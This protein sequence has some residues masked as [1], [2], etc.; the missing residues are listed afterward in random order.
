[1]T[2]IKQA[3][4]SWDEYGQP[5][6]IEFDD[7]YF[8]KD[9]GLEESRYVFLQHN[10]LSQRMKQLKNNDIFVIGETGFGSG[11]NFLCAWQLFLNVSP[12]EGRL[13]FISVEKS[14]LTRQDLKK[15]LLLWRELKEFSE[16]LITQYE[17]V[18]DGFQHFVF[19]SGR[20]VLTL[21]VGDVIDQLPKL[22]T[23]IDAWFLDGFSPAKNPQMWNEGLFKQLA[24]LS[25]QE[26]SFATFTSAGFVK[27]GLQEAGFN[28]LKDKGF[29]RKR[30][31]LYGSFQKME[32]P[33][34]FKKTRP[35]VAPWFDR[36]ANKPFKER[37]AVVIGAGIAGASTAA[38]LAS[39]GWH[40]VVLERNADIAMEGSGN[41]QGILYLKLSAHQTLQSR[42][43]VE[44]FGYTRRLLAHL[45]SAGKLVENQD[46][47]NCGV[48][49][50]A[51]NEKEQ[52]R[53][54]QL[55]DAFSSSLLSF[56]TREQASKIAGVEVAYEGLLF[57]EAGWV[58]PRNLC[59]ALLKHPNIEVRCY[60]SVLTINQ[61]KVSWQAMQN[62]KILAEADIM[63]LA[64]ATEAKNFMMTN[65]L[66]VKAIRGQ[67]TELP[68]NNMTK[69]NTVICGDG[70]VSPAINE[71]Y[72]IGATFNFHAIDLKPN[73]QEH[74]EN[75]QMLKSVSPSLA[76]YLEVDR[77]ALD[78]LKGKV[79]YR[80]TATDYL[81]I[82]GPVADRKLFLNDYSALIKDS[83]KIPNIPCRWHEGLFLNVAHGSRGL[84]TAPLC[85]ELLANW[86]EN[87]PFIVEQDLLEA[88]HANRFYVRELRYFRP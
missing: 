76:N 31:M 53:Q 44:G 6:S 64:N 50:L 60:Q 49:Q 28:V 12:D 29:A 68:A 73:K 84:I 71:T 47:Q 81:P 35:A 14:P 88:C 72:C 82:V 15:S 4:L 83:K 42:L 80:C 85:G 52:Y 70:Y 66:P 79:A 11:L 87:E 22:N 25:K 67:T 36:L 40:V 55:A 3:A 58:K 32:R 1:M 17:A 21:L 63:I 51:F 33:H 38:S 77:L 46:W 41:A 37:K 20:V 10:Q 45:T 74:L 48:L 8:S 13:H 57:P 59:H 27:R 23:K 61:T 7:I 86:V 69:L 65:S 9:S 26:T 30:E 24:R 56:V 16:Q 34:P 5:C 43:L 54:R 2:K 62:N 78:E 19:E 75:I 18:H 39:R